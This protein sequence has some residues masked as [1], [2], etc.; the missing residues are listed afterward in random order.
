M[1][2]FWI[3]LLGAHFTGVQ[4][5]KLQGRVM[6]TMPPASKQAAILARPSACGG[7]EKQWTWSI[8]IYIYIITKNC[9]KISLLSKP[10]FHWL[11]NL[12]KM[13]KIVG[14]GLLEYKNT[15][16]STFY[17]LD[18][19]SYYIRQSFVFKT[20]LLKYIE[21]MITVLLRKILHK[22]SK[23]KK[24]PHFCIRSGNIKFC[25]QF[26]SCLPAPNFSRND[27]SVWS[28][29]KQ[30]IGKVSFDIVNVMSC[31]IIGLHKNVTVW[32]LFKNET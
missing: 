14:L 1:V 11:W 10:I 12:K 21:I 24:F 7:R 6:N 9:K 31:K 3:F 17:S 23:I 20:S 30:C 5:S 4:G 8:Y 25:I 32:E 19:Y 22:C 28:I 15:F 18:R 26:R 13:N 29:L 16:Y 2:I 27:F